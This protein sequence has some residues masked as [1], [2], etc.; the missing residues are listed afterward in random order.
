MAIFSFIES[1]SEV[2]KGESL[3]AFFTLKQ[4]E[5]YLKDHFAGFPVMP[6]VLQIESLRQAASRLLAETEGRPGF[7]RLGTLDSAKYGQFVKPGSRLKIFVQMT[8]KENQAAH[9]EG[10]ID[11][12]DGDKSMGRVILAGFSLVPVR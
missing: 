2:K 7:Y 3:T 1:V 10:R 11:L 9:F 4:E 8:K 5:E 6:G 12:V